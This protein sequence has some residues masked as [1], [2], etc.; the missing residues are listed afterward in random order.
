[1]YS[2][3]VF[4]LFLLHC[5]Y[6]VSYIQCL[7]IHELVKRGKHSILNAEVFFLFLS[8]LCVCGGG[9]GERESHYN[10]IIFKVTLKTSEW[11]YEV[12]NACH[13][14]CACCNT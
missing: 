14:P 6:A 7:C 9:G 11:H 8:V 4:I 12:S 2:Y 5:V 13:T 3:T 10:L 1:M